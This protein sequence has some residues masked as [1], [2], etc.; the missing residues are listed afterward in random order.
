MNASADSG[1]GQGIYKSTDGGKSWTLLP[2]STFAVNRSIGSVVIDPTN[3]NTI[4]V[5]TTRGVRGFSAVIGGATGN[6]PPGTGQPVGLYKSVDG[7][8]TFTLL[9]GS[10]AVTPGGFSEGVPSVALDPSNPAIVY[11][12][13]FGLGVFPWD[14]IRIRRW[15]TR[16]RDLR[17]LSPPRTDTRACT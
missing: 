2:G 13:A 9:F 4:Y 12:S 7:G 17:S 3:A 16:S 1:A 5:G 8:N 10:L 15:K 14:S 11:L 6:P